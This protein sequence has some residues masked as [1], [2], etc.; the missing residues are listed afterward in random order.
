M[1]PKG[2]IVVLVQSNCSGSTLLYFMPTLMP[3]EL[4]RVQTLQRNRDLKSRSWRAH[5]LGRDDGLEWPTVRKYRTFPC[6]C[7]MMLACG[8]CLSKTMR[9][10]RDSWPRACANKRTPL[11]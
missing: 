6:T 8:Y 7:R 5:Q 1:Q 10:S 9:A 4:S 3:Q 2:R 11:T